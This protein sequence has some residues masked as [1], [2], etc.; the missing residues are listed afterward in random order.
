EGVSLTAGFARSVV[1]R[2]GN[3]P[4]ADELLDLALGLNAIVTQGMLLGAPSRLEPTAAPPNPR[5]T[6]EEPGESPTRALGTCYRCRPGGPIAR[7]PTG[8]LDAQ[9]HAIRRGMS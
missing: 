6:S 2:L 7:L 3:T 9:A 4:S 8:R 1:D 5:A